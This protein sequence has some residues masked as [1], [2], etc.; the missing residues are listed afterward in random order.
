MLTQSVHSNTE[1]LQ[2]VCTVCFFLWHLR[3]SSFD[4][5]LN[6]ITISLTLK[7]ASTVLA[8]TMLLFFSVMP[9][10]EYRITYDDGSVYHGQVISE[11]SNLLR[12]GF[13]TH[14][15]ESGVA[16][17]GEWSRDRRCGQGKELDKT[18]NVVFDGSWEA[19]RKTSGTYVY[20]HKQREREDVIRIEI[21]GLWENGL[22]TAGNFCN[23]GG[24]FYCGELKLDQSGAPILDGRGK[25]NL[26][27]SS[28]L[29]T[30]GILYNVECCIRHLL[31]FFYHAL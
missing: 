17:K 12:H 31:A 26:T 11:D 5:T 10:A 9:K 16:Y 15:E 3:K 19:D 21:E 2:T 27:I 28:I 30:V 4:Q 8:T 1:C 13:G 25:S 22:L 18:G 24:D 14:T 20:H 23:E 29:L 6:N 7:E